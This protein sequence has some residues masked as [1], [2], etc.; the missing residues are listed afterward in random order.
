MDLFKVRTDEELL[1]LLKAGDV[2]A[3]DALYKRYW[4]KLY[5]AAYRRLR[6][7]EVC[8]EIVQDFFTSLWLKRDSL[9][10]HTS[11]NAYVNTSV[12]YQVFSYYHKNATRRDY[13]EKMVFN[14]EAQDAM[15]ENLIDVKTISRALD[16]RVE[17]LPEKCRAVYVLSRKEHLN[18]K[19]IAQMLG[20]S[21]KTVE[22]H[23][24]K[25]LRNLRLSVKDLI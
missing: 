19:Q 4:S 15:I 22:N 24:T 5:I 8:E 3:F 25:A 10:I 14:S 7:R 20:I 1:G 17:A 12:K 16:E 9:E 13:Q 21:E 18:N 23:M 2:A 11:F 6:D